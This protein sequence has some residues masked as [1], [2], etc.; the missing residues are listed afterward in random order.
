MK[1]IVK[2]AIAALLAL[3]VSSCGKIQEIHMTSYKIVSLSP[4]GLRGLDV[5]LDL[6][7]DNPAMQ[8]TVSDV[9]AEL[10]RQ[11][12]SLGTFTCSK[13][14][15]VKAKTVANYRVDGRISL[16][17]GIS[18]FQVLGYAAKFDM[19]DYSLSYGATVTLKS[20]LHAKLQKNKIP[21]KELFEDKE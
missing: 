1:N 19:D 14:I 17:D 4:V 16:S 18:V 7:I 6:G 15:L 21:M 13:P 11:G 10:F 20:G 5:A 9:T 12:V 3:I 2:I 8:F